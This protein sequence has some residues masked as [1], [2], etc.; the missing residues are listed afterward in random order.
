MQRVCCHGTLMVN[1]VSVAGS[2]FGYCVISPTPLVHEINAVRGKFC[3][4]I[5]NPR[6][7]QSLL[8]PTLHPCFKKIS[9]SMSHCLRMTPSLPDP[10][11]ATIIYHRIRKRFRRARPKRKSIN[12]PNIDCT[13]PRIFARFDKLAKTSGV[14]ISLRSYGVKVTGSGLSFCHPQFSQYMAD[15]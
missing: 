9:C 5:F 15:P 13:T 1:L 8:R 6:R 12:V 2:D 3:I 14:I 4:A 10:F 7:G 11:T